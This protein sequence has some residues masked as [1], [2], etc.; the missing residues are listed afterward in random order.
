M[1]LLTSANASDLY[2]EAYDLESG[3]SARDA[4]IRVLQGMRRYAKGV[5]T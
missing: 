5:C 1:G 4:K 3:L 2:L